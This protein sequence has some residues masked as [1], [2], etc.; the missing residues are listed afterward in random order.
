[1]NQILNQMNNNKTTKIFDGKDYAARSRTDIKNFIDTIRN[2]D[3]VNPVRAPKLVIIQVKGNKA[4]DV[5]VRN[6]IKACNEVGIEVEH[7]L[8]DD[9]DIENYKSDYM[10]LIDHIIHF[11]DKANNDENV[12]GIILQLPIEWPKLYPVDYAKEGQRYFN[13]ITEIIINRIKPEKD[14]DGLTVFSAG[15][16]MQDRER[17]KESQHN[18]IFANFKYFLPA[19][20]YGI[21]HILS[22]KEISGIDN[23]YNKRIVIIGRSNLL[24]K[25]LFHLLS[26]KTTGNGMV[27][28]LH[29]G[30]SEQIVNETIKQSDIVICCAGNSSKYIVNK[31]N[32]KDGAIVIDAAINVREITDEYGNKKRKLYGDADFEN[33]KDICSFITPVPGGVGPMT[34]TMILTNVIQAWQNNIDL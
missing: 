23:F 11:I 21:Y 16:L 8:I 6:K 10:M 17:V 26:N 25:P 29:T 12:D 1:M 2:L 32:I 31:D 15:M 22:N 30:C 19:T 18:S 3:I 14:V 13:E 7:N 28:L 33:I 24:G 5:Y 34:I 27:T 20:P 4:S 9:I